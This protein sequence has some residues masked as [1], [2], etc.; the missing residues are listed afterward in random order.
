MVRTTK[1]AAPVFGLRREIDKLFEDTF[2]NAGAPLLASNGWLPAVDVKETNDALLFDLEMPGV[3]E[4]RLEITCEGGVLAVAGEKSAVKKE[5]DEGKWHIVERTFGSFR[6]S[7]QLPTNVQEDHIEA[8]LAN[9][10]LH[11]RVPKMEQPK[12]KRIE[13]K[14]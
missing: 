10:V 3:A 13:V 5:G 4:D 14:K 7:F 9:G 2:G 11:L 1:F 12:P 6:R 8:T